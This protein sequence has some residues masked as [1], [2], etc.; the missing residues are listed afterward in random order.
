MCVCIGYPTPYDW[1]YM[2]RFW[3]S[4]VSG[5][6]MW[7]MRGIIYDE[8]GDSD[9]W[10]GERP[11][12]WRYTSTS[13]SWCQVCLSNIQT[14]WSDPSVSKLLQS[15]AQISRKSY[16][17]NSGNRTVL[18]NQGLIRTFFLRSFHTH[19]IFEA[20]SLKG[21]NGLQLTSKAKGVS[22]I[23]ADIPVM[24]ANSNQT[25]LT[26]VLSDQLWYKSRM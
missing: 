25:V 23:W 18:V 4:G 21:V 17:C 5:C 11:D 7:C 10:L 1:V 19:S 13:N 12:H 8:R 14:Q 22:S 16:L 9:C 3:M 20:A 15:R 6:V 26:D 24:M 2:I